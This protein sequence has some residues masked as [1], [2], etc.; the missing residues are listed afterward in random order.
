M[1]DSLQNMQ[2]NGI[3]ERY[4]YLNNE[5]SC[6]NDNYIAKALAASTDWHYSGETCDLGNN[7]FINNATGF[8]GLPGGYRDD[9]WISFA[10]VGDFGNWWTSSEQFTSVWYLKLYYHSQEVLMPTETKEMGFSVRC[11]R[12]NW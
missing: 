9:E 3:I 6:D 4:C 10:G 8:S 2:N 11:L 1:I 7:L 5:D 12:Y